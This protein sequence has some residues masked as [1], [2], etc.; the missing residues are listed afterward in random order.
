MWSQYCASAAANGRTRT[1]RIHRPLYVPCE[2]EWFNKSTIV[3]SEA[4][5]EGKGDK[6]Q[7]DIQGQASP[8]GLLNAHPGS[9]RC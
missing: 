9:L 4:N 2:L 6:R 3:D 1:V 8:L 7:I 5:R